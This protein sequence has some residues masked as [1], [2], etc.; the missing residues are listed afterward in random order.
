MLRSQTGRSWLL[1]PVIG[2]TLTLDACTQVTSMGPPGRSQAQSGS[3]PYYM[4]PPGKSRSA[5]EDDRTACSG[6]VR[7]HNDQGYTDCMIAHGNRAFEFSPTKTQAD[8]QASMAEC[9]RVSRAVPLTSQQSAFDNCLQARGDLVPIGQTP[10]LGQAQTQA[11]RAPLPQVPSA[12]ICT[13]YAKGNE[14]MFS[15]CMESKRLD[16]QISC[17]EA[18]NKQS[19]LF[20]QCMA[21]RGFRVSGLPEEYNVSS[22]P[23]S[24]NSPPSGH[25]VTNEPSHSESTAP[26]PHPSF[27]GSW[28]IL[29]AGPGHSVGIFEHPCGM[30]ETRQPMSWGGCE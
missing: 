15:Y 9:S 10:A 13:N 3:R 24:I 5:Y 26:T 4:A 7:P 27:G 17:L 12:T 19:A 18:T 23:S 14:Q 25:F 8:I 11:Y 1:V 22:P 6:V 29:P 2:L 21:G 16:A 20:I 30:F 28:P